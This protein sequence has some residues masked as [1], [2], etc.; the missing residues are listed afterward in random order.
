MLN[1]ID[2][3]FLSY[4]EKLLTKKR[5]RIMER[6]SNSIIAPFFKGRTI[7]KS[8]R[9]FYFKGGGSSSYHSGYW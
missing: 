6:Q 4:F 7:I 2:K 1:I 5:F 8:E 3:N 9:Q